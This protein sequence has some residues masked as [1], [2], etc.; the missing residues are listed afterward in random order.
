MRSLMTTRGRAAAIFLL[1]LALNLG[2]VFLFVNT[3]KFP[4]LNS[5]QMGDS[6]FDIAVNLLAGQGYFQ[7]FEN[8]RYELWRPPTFPLLLAGLFAIFGKSYVVMRVSL[9]LFGAMAAATAFYLGRRLWGERVGTIAGFAVAL[10]PGTIF[11]SGLTGPENLIAFLLLLTFLI[12]LE[13]RD[14]LSMKQAVWAGVVIALTALTK[15]FYVIFPLLA[16]AWLMVQK[17]DK[18][19]LARGAAVLCASFALVVSP[20][21]IRNWVTVGKPR[22]AT[23]DAA[24]VFWTANT[25]SWLTAPHTNVPWPPPEYFQS[26]ESL[27]SMD[28][29]T[30][31]RWFFDEAIKSIKAHPGLYAARVVDRVWVMWKPFPYA[32][33]YPGLMSKLRVAVMVVT[34]VPMFALFLLGVWKLRREARTFS[35]V[36]LVILAVTGST[37]LVHSVIRYRT[38]MEPLMILLAAFA[39]DELLRARGARRAAA[40]AP[41]VG[42]AATPR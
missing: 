16:A 31:D 23:T 19:R 37:A 18:R 6:G 2:F 33:H 5:K 1:S 8:L 41:T 39:A 22:L 4:Q 35:I 10:N 42:D 24:M 28:E 29:L 11:S 21:V 38:P 30:R 17:A 14:T 32:Q 13:L 40:T 7:W 15:T 9:A 12:L 20:W 36:Y 3:N 26:F 25:E 27:R 34:F